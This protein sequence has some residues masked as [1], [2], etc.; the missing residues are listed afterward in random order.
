MKRLGSD[1]VIN[2]NVDQNIPEQWYNDVIKCYLHLFKLVQ[3]YLK[4]MASS[5]KW[6]R[7]LVFITNKSPRYQCK[8]SFKRNWNPRELLRSLKVIAVWKIIVKDE[9]V[10]ELWEAY[11][12]H[13]VVRTLKLFLSLIRVF[14]SLSS[15]LIVR[16][17]HQPTMAPHQHINLSIS[18]LIFESFTQ[19]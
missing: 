2:A 1:H 8:L 15:L 7:N 9:E 12:H 4:R 3:S 10:K 17:V 16:I 5:F 19:T 14:A 13:E 11:I 6:N 18:Y